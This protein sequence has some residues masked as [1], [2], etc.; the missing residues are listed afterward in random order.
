M[1]P[2]TRTLTIVTAA[3]LLFALAVAPA[4]AL[5][6]SGTQADPYL[7]SSAEDLDSLVQTSTYTYYLQTADIVLPNWNPS[8][9][10]DVFATIYGDYNGGGFIIDGSNF[11]KSSNH[12]YNNGV[13]SGAAGSSFRQI[14][15][16]NFDYY[17]RNAGLICGINVNALNVEVSDIIVSS[18]TIDGHVSPGLLKVQHAS[19]IVVLNS[20]LKQEGGGS[21]DAAYRR[22]G[23][24]TTSSSDESFSLTF[25]NSIVIDSNVLYSTSNFRYSGYR[26]GYGTITNCYAA[27][28]LVNSI[29]PSSNIGA[30]AYNGATIT[31]TEY[32]SESWWKT[33]MSAWDWENVWQWNDETNLPELRNAN[34]QAVP[35]TVSAVTVSPTVGGQQTAYTLSTTA[36]TEAAGG[37][38]GYQWSYSTNAGTTW[39]EITGATTTTYQ[40]I[41]GNTIAGDVY[42]KVFVTG[43]DGGTADSWEEGFTSVKA[44]VN[45]APAISEITAS[46]PL[47]KINTPTTLTAIFADNQQATYQWYYS[48][49]G[50]AGS[51]Q[52]ISGAT[53]PTAEYTPRVT[54]TNYVKII[55]TNQYSE[56]SELQTSFLVLQTYTPTAVPGGTVDIS[57]PAE[58]KY[59]GQKQFTLSAE[60]KGLEYYTPNLAYLAHDNA[61]YYL[62]SAEQEVIPV[63]NTTGGTIANAYIGQHTGIITDTNGNTALY[64]YNQNNWQY[65]EQNAASIIAS[66]T[67]YGATISSGTLNI[68]N[69]NGNK[70][71]STASTLQN[72]AGNDN[73]NVFAGYTGK[74][75]TYY[76]LSG[77]TIN[78][79][80][81]TITQTIT[82]LHQIPG[83]ANWIV[84]TDSNTLIIEITET[85][86]YNLVASS[87]TENA[88]THTQAT[89]INV[90]IG[91]DAPNEI[92]I[93]GADGE[94]DGTYVTG[95]TLNDASIAKATGL[96]ALT[97]GEDRQVYILAK[98]TSSTWQL[99]QVVGFGDVVD[100]SQISTTGT[101]AAVA[102]GL[103]LYLL[104]ASD[105]ETGTYMLHG[106][107]ISSTGSPYAGKPI[108]INGDSIRTDS[109]GKFLYPVKP[110][111]VYTIIADS[112]TTEYTTTNAAL[113][114]LA[115][116]LKPN[117]FAQSV[118]YSTD[119]NSETRNFEMVYTDTRDLTDSVTW[120]IR[121]TGT[122]TIVST[123]TVP[124]GQTAYWEVP[125]DKT[126]TS[127]QI[128]MIADRQGTN[129]ENTWMIT[130]DGKNPIDIPGLDESGK[131]II[132]GCV[133]LIFGGL[134]GV[135]HSTK[136]AI[137]TVA[138]AGVM[139]YLGLLNIPWA[140][141]IV[142]GTLAILA[143]LGR[144]GA[145]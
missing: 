121:E 127:Y 144:G 87:D 56:S 99:M 141:I 96:Y 78:S 32:N 10:T 26:V 135:M 55:A 64:D 124:A 24:T 73:T 105:V 91:V 106:V 54:G 98:S 109:T 69:T 100:I 22:V 93:I 103:K 122:Q 57:I 7:I 34:N 43:A 118:S 65:I 140:I 35:P 47:Q 49:T 39:Q 16:V 82:D 40:W 11:A 131:T 60:L 33:T 115:I 62:D 86:T 9:D 83:T 88:L 46:R 79:A 28:T 102:T 72:L 142:A 94:T 101:Y 21:G 129:V 145:S 130:P 23:I 125:L 38:T 12:N 143:A 27:N 116:R 48:A 108:T 137:L 95:A 17:T 132:F 6:G 20:E 58:N 50:T 44:T 75:I 120:V 2:H 67:A 76:W 138:A 112:T 68:Y 134:F 31:A 52:A 110:N 114:Q 97:G 30:N 61:L 139:T 126:F 13:F 85:G 19:N 70:L 25:E 92:Y 84:S 37:I 117:P 89:S 45:A 90:I 29:T 107:I 71:E 4:A 111:T 113:Q 128:S 59:Q 133:L 119:Y 81:Q 42:L 15:F 77:T 3:L 123:Q 63:S 8:F 18:C 5:E 66:T 53:Q 104:E 51:W 1:H 36:T 136:G 74:T 14:N 41:P 80:S